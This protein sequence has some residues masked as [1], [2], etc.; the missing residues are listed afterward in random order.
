M[1]SRH[2]SEWSWKSRLKAAELKTII[3]EYEKE[4][5]HRTISDNAFKSLKQ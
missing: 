3:E 5:N 4:I 1:N 2:L